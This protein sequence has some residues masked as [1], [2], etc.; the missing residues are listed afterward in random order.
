[1]KLFSLPDIKFENYYEESRFRLMWNISFV[2]I[3]LMSVVSIFNYS[4]EQYSS[5]PN[6][7]A[8]GFAIIALIVLKK[9][10]EYKV[11][12]IIVSLLNLILISSVFFTL[13]NVIH[14]TTPLWGIMNIL[15]T[16]F[17]LGHIWGFAVLI[18]QFI[19]IFFYFALHLSDNIQS[20]APFDAADI[21]NIIVEYAICGAGIGYFIFKFIKTSKFAEKQFTHTN[22]EL[23]KQ[24]SVIS[25]QNEEKEIMLKEIHHRVKNNLQVITSL[26]R[27]QS[28]EIDENNGAKEFN[29]A[30]NR[31]KAMAL[32]HEKM[33]QN[34]MLSKI[35]LEEYVRSL[36]L[37]LIDSY[38]LDID[39]ELEVKSDINNVNSKT[40]VPL[41]LLLNELVSNSLKHAF[42]NI[43]EAKI[44][45]SL[46]EQGNDQFKLLFSDNGTWKESQSN[47][48]FGSELIEAM[49]EQMEGEVTLTKSDTG[50]YYQFVLNNISEA[51]QSAI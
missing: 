31:V 8:I 28:Y 40:I 12:S 23:N 16:F 9:T 25:S 2:F 3:F 4:N 13:R 26:L 30:I 38:S 24:N 29:E 33:Y 43:P 18:I 1:M 6:L 14:Y 19:V 42:D 37:D 21:T 47:S 36:A 48:S 22:E 39:I 44:M 20:I 7:I 5:T 45:V 34:Q 10:K 17:M 27:L 49:T 32:I 35:N 41:A 46:M 11:I 50:T 51:P 15:F